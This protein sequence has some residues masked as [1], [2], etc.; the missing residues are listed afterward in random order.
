MRGTVHL[1]LAGFSFDQHIEAISGPA[2]EDP[3]GHFYVLDGFRP[4]DFRGRVTCLRVLGNMAT[5]GGVVTQSREP[6]PPE[7]T[8]VI[9]NAMDNGE[10]GDLDQSRVFF[11]L[12]QRLWCVRRS[13]LP[14]RSEGATT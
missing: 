1:N 2:G 4:L 3:K 7:G 8:G 5:V 14:D 9:I 13:P 11:N 6:L 10:P 12:P